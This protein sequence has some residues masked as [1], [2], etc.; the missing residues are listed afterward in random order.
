MTSQILSRLEKIEALMAPR[1]VRFPRFTILYVDAADGRPTGR[2][3][4][5]RHSGDQIIEEELTMPVEELIKLGE[6][7]L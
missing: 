7:A 6:K 3:T 4:R 5:V 2:V 1:E